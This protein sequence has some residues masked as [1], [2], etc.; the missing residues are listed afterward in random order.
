MLGAILTAPALKVRSIN[1]KLSRTKTAR[2]CDL[3][4]IIGNLAR[5]RTVFTFTEGDMTRLTMKLLSAMLANTVSLLTRP[6]RMPGTT[7]SHAPAF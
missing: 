3:L 7:L 4:G 2:T 1:D 6:I 5:P